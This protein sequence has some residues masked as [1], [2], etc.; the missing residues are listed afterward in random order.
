[1]IQR[2]TLPNGLSLLLKEDH[3]RPVVFSGLWVRVGALY[4]PP[5]LRGWSH[6]LEHNFFKGTTRRS[7]ARIAAEIDAAGAVLEAGTGYDSTIYY[8]VTPA[9]SFFRVLDI[10][11][12]II[13]S[14]T[15]DPRALDR[16]REVLLQESR[17]YED[18]PSGY[19]F[20]WNRLLRLMFRRHPYRNSISGPDKN[21]R[22]TP[23]ADIMAFKEKFYVAANMLY[24]AV[25]DFS[26]RQ[27]KQRLE[28]LFHSL[29][30]GPA[31]R[32]EFPR[33]PEQKALRWEA[34]P[35]NVHQGYLKVGFRT[36]GE[37]D[38]QLYALQM[39]FKILVGG[40]GSRLVRR[41]RDREGLVSQV[42]FLEEYH[43]ELGVVVL[44][45]VFPPE[46]GEKVLRALFA[47]LT[48]LRREP[49]TTKELEKIRR[50]VN[51]QLIRTLETVEGEGG[52]L[53]TY[54]LLGDYNFLLQRLN[55]YA[56]LTSED[57]LET[58]RRF[59]SP[60]KAALHFLHPREHMLTLTRDKVRKLAH[61]T[62]PKISRRR[63]RT[64][65][66]TGRKLILENGLKVVVQP[67][68][69]VPLLA[70]GLFADFGQRRETVRNSGLAHMLQRLWTKGSR[71][72][73]EYEIIR[74]MESLGSELY[75]FA[76]R[77]I[78]GLHLVSGSGE[79]FH[80]WRYLKDLIRNPSFSPERL[81]QEK[82]LVLKQLRER[83]DHPEEVASRNLFRAFFGSRGYG[84]PLRG[85]PASVVRFSSRQLQDNYRRQFTPEHLVF[86]LVGNYP[87]VLLEEEILPFLASLPPG[88]GSAAKAPAYPRI[89][90]IKKVVE[91]SPVRQS[92]I[93][94]GLP[95][96][97]WLHR[98]RLP[99]AVL[100]SVLSAMGGGL[101]QELRERRGLSYYTG[102]FQAN[103]RDA[104]LLAAYAGVAVGREEEAL[105]TVFRE[106]QRLRTRGVTRTEVDR[107][108]AQR[109]GAWAMDSQRRLERASLF[110]RL[111]LKGI[112]FKRYADFPRIMER[113]T[114][115]EVNRVAARYLNAEN[116]VVSI[117]KP[118]GKGA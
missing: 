25:G 65:A 92:V 43:G 80:S 35:G 83:D 5:H 113:I 7:G 3:R 75:S 81:E 88:S 59:L 17:M 85:L 42:S 52:L 27:L 57:L 72:Y 89:R 39:L 14:S 69:D 63:S 109:L 106:L 11:A 94:V 114:R 107:A 95:G 28:K 62:T 74:A 45:L 90:G 60:E 10:Q 102:F 101:F 110:A 31:P 18:Q 38:P 118:A 64:K 24:V 67:W 37:P 79:F 99:L 77:D 100:E 47:E 22:H 78:S 96:V 51:I 4:E 112:S 33:E 70:C 48:R 82:K 9:K 61:G 23:Y 105:E 108:K 98:D 56:T 68:D 55:A 36:P 34:M 86:S 115:E 21:L 2:F 16:E 76:T 66:D 26:T 44:D 84:L 49:V 12:D 53:G 117:V 91:F 19:G 103:F 97:S 40:P 32:V 73:G 1:V 116:C 20:A 93:Y 71:N 8:A 58:A 50:S 29:P 15:F 87:K 104:G 30:P 41:L 54:E 111:E 13:T 46:N 6:G